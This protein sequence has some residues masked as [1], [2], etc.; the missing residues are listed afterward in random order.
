MFTGIIEESGKIAALEKHADGAK[1]KIS[2][3]IVTEDTKKAIRLRL[4]AFV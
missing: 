1:M 4:T 3:Q 2:A